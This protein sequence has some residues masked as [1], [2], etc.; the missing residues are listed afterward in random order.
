VIAQPCVGSAYQLWSADTLRAQKMTAKLKLR[1]SGRCLWAPANQTGTLQWGCQ[2][3]PE[4]DLVLTDQGDGGYTIQSGGNHLCL[5]IEGASHDSGAWIRQQTCDGG[6]HQRWS[7]GAREDGGYSLVSMHTGQCADIAG[8]E[9]S[10]G[11]VLIQWGCHDGLNQR[12]DVVDLRSTAA[13]TTSLQN[14]GSPE[15]T[16]LVIADGHGGYLTHDPRAILRALKQSGQDVDQNLIERVLSPLQRQKLAELG[17]AWDDGAVDLNVE[18]RM[19][20]LYTDA[21]LSQHG[22]TL[23]GNATFVPAVGISGQ[24]RFDARYVG[25]DVSFNF[26]KDGLAIKGANINTPIASGGFSA[27]FFQ[28]PDSFDFELWGGSKL[29]FRFELGGL[30][31]HFSLDIDN[32][33]KLVGFVEYGAEYLADGTVEAFNSVTSWSEGALDA[34]EDAL[35]D[36][37]DAIGDIGED[38]GEGF[39]DFFGC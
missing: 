26:G 34:V 33:A 19:F 39:C 36:A 31:L 5:G 35:G 8:G 7:I 11:G 28:I 38:I 21:E 16:A 13:M 29:G 4:Q 24:V 22:V 30:N 14:V 37:I 15:G 20:T 23:G 2:D 17:G 6:R 18:F 12:F 10:D 32:S 25:G 3:A 27:N 1:H 9:P